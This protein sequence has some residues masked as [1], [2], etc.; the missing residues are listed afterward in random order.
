[1]SACIS[2]HGEYSSHEIADG[3]LICALCGFFDEEMALVI[4]AAHEADTARGV[5][6]ERER[7]A[8]WLSRHI[9]IPV[10]A[11]IRNGDHW[12]DGEQ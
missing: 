6:L 5:A 11:S 2:G 3:E 9:H 12:K 4:I 7:I 1:M 8:S 10:A